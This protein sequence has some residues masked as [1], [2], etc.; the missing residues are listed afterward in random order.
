MRRLDMSKKPKGFKSFDGLMRKLVK[1]PPSELDKPSM[2]INRRGCKGRLDK[3]TA[4]ALTHAAKKIHEAYSKI[5]PASGSGFFS[6]P[7]TTSAPNC[8]NRPAR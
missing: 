4:E 1:V 5:R 2:H 6:F 7:G 3:K 8:K